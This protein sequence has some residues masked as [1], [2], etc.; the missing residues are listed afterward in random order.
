MLRAVGFWRQSE[1]EESDLPHPSALVR[2][3][4]A[5]GDLARVVSYLRSGRTYTR[6]RGHS[7]CRFACGVAH[8]SMGSRDLG[9]GVWLWPEG[10]AHYVESHSVCLPDELV[11]TMR[12]HGWQAPAEEALPPEEERV[13]QGAA[14]DLTFWVGWAR[15][16]RKRHD[17]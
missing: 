9:D 6:W 13:E 15:G 8:A 2:P 17:T 1:D 10:L 7:F 3:G 14:A 11:Q 16:L 12:S 5:G 4:W